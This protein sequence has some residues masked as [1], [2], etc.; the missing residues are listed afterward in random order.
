LIDIKDLIKGDDCL[1]ELFLNKR[2]YSMEKP[3]IYDDYKPSNGY[4]DVQ[5]PLISRY[6]AAKSNM[7]Y[8][9][10]R[11]FAVCLTHDVD[12][13]YPTFIHTLA[14]SLCYLR[15]L[16]FSELISNIFWRQSGKKSLYLTFDDIIQLELSYGA[17]STFFFLSTNEDIHRFRYDVEDVGHELGNIVDR[18][19]EVG[20]HGGYYSYNDAARIMSE[21]AR[22]EKV[23]ERRVCGY[24]NHYL[25]MRIPDTWSTLVGCGFSYDSTYGFSNAVGFRNGL[26]HPFTPYNYVT[27]R[28][29]DILEF[30]L[31]VMDSVLLRNGGSMEGAWSL[32]KNLLESVEECRGVLTL[33]WHNDVFGSYFKNDQKKLYERI[34]EYCHGKGAWLTNCI[35][36]YDWWGKN[37][38]NA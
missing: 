36:L 33:N 22:L 4:H 34:L 2:E 18:G 8:P 5:N 24:R 19:F 20:L 32:F 21:K 15:D 35:D 16:K 23:L 12:Y 26:C 29:M 7:Y 38:F 25:R 11:K 31:N 27:K 17:K 6:L 14:S 3:E 13:I 1:T 9:E 30:P 37:D 28:S 10:N